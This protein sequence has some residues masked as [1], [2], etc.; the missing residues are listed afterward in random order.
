MENNTHIS[1][2]NVIYCLKS[3]R[4]SG[5]FFQHLGWVRRFAL[6][7]SPY[8]LQVRENTDQE[9]SEYG[10]FLRSNAII[11]APKKLRVTINTKS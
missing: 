9:N 11:T 1:H 3:T 5:P 4:I 10:Q 8:S 7:K 6:Y 2:F